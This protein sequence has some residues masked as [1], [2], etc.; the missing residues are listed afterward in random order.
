MNLPVPGATPFWGSSSVWDTL[1][2]LEL[3][4]WLKM[5][6][7]TQGCSSLEMFLH[8][9]LQQQTPHGCHVTLAHRTLLQ[10][11]MPFLMLEATHLACL[12]LHT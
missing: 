5:E 6:L 1:H 4:I 11:R 3:R 10:P 2:L 7:V 8:K 9:S 12:P